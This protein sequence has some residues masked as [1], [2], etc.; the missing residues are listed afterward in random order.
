MP[1][2]P[3]VLARKKPLDCITYHMKR[4]FA[5]NQQAYEAGGVLDSKT[6]ELLGLVAFAVL[7]CDR[8]L[9]PLRSD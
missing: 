2:L 3:R 7:L 9:D 1:F 5:L 8:W 6:K 4:H